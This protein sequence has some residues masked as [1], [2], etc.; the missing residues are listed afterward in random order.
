M[1]GP[2]KIDG[3]LMEECNNFFECKFEINNRTYPT[4]EHYFQCCKCINDSDFNSVYEANTAMASWTHG[5]KVKLRSDWESV[6]VTSMYNGNRAKFFQ[7]KELA[8]KLIA[9]TGD[10][11]FRSSTPFW[12]Y[13]NG[14]II[15]R[16]R[17]ELKDDLEVAEAIRVKIEEYEN[18][19]KK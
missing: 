11:E 13:W 12:N 6:K 16:I 10:V 18:S 9:T 15:M 5:N 7:N 3:K 19:K 1:G 17:A 14:M 8:D 2:A 4:S